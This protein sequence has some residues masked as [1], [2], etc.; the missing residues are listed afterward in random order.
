MNYIDMLSKLGAGSAHPGGFVATLEQFAKFPLPRNGHILEVG[1]GTGRTACYLAEQGYQVTAIDIH[2]QMIDKAKLRARAHGVEVRFEVADVCELPYSDEQFDV[3]LVESVTVFTQA[4]RSAQ[5][6]HRVLKHGGIL[7]DREMVVTEHI[8]TDAIQALSK[9]FGF[10]HIYN[11]N[12]W[13][14]IL[15]ESGFEDV[16]FV[17][18]NKFTNDTLDQQGQL[19]DQ[20]QFIDEGVMLDAAIWQRVAQHAEIIADNT[21]YLAYGLIRAIK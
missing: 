20:H 12:Q 13:L 16:E 11:E 17:E 18:I 8:P 10:P 9:F 6:Y 4:E 19:P 15:R 5:Q 1:C 21:P 7:Y 3:I 14:H 2:S